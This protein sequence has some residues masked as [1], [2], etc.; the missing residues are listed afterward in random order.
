MAWFRHDFEHVPLP[1]RDAPLGGVHVLPLTLPLVSTVSDV[2]VGD[3][4]VTLEVGRL[5][6]RAVLY[7]DH[8]LRRGVFTGSLTVQLFSARY[9]FVHV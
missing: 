2:T 1:G 9:V 8:L 4:T 6:A 7:K 3:I 5:D